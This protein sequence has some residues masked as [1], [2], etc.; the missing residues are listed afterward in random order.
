M[1][2][3]SLLKGYKDRFTGGL[4]FR[5]E[6]GI[7]KMEVGCGKCLGCRMDYR[8]M[9]AMRIAHE[10][11]LHEFAG[12][13]CFITLTYRD[14]SACETLEQFNNGYYV[15]NDWSLHPKHFT[16]FMKRLRKFFE[17][18]KV[19][20]YYVGEYGR[21]CKHG[22]DLQMVKCP[23]CNVG[24]PHFHACLF[25]CSF[26]DLEPYQSDGGV[27]RYTSWSLEKLWKYGFVDVGELNYTSAQY[28]AGY[29]LKKITGEKA[30]DWYTSVDLD[31][32]VTFLEPEYARMSRGG[33]SG[34]GKKC[35]IG[36]G[37]LEKYHGDVFPSDEVPVPGLGV[38]RGVPR[39]YDEMFAEME[40]EVMENVKKKRVKYLKENSD[41]LTL[42]R[43]EAKFKCKKA[44]LKI[45]EKR[46][47]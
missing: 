8:R 2:C 44:N 7:E 32:V 45:R 28:V 31:G 1:P 13:N 16:D 36:A 33:T 26:Q 10:A 15:P 25:N 21:K 18:Q 30:V 4:T 19:R 23:L 39:Y 42:E 43:L 47:L 40:P 3:F 22:I 24:R 17:P 37:W 6:N 14:K 11:S 12:G 29:M 35:G 27:I 20:Y 9:W 5:R 41:D 38:V 46:S 34:K